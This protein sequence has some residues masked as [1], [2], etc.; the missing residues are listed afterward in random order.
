MFDQLTGKQRDTYKEAGI[1]DIPRLRELIKKMVTDGSKPSIWTE[2]KSDGLQRELNVLFQEPYEFDDSLEADEVFR[3]T[4]FM[5]LKKV[6][7]GIVDYA[8]DADFP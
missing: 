7:V 4:W 8:D 5:S 6:T 3:A 2:R 1:E